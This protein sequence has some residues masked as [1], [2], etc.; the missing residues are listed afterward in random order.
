METPMGG[1]IVDEPRKGGEF[2]DN[3]RQEK[4]G[5]GNGGK[6]SWQARG[7]GNEKVRGGAVGEAQLSGGGGSGGMRQRRR[8]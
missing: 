2:R 1:S 3:P 8:R 4:G 6:R 7:G 5:D